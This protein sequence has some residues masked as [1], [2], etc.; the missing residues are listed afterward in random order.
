M[1]VRHYAF[2][3][4]VPDDEGER[5]MAPKRGLRQPRRVGLS[6]DQSWRTNVP[7]SR[8]YERWLHI[9]NRRVSGPTDDPS[10]PA[11]VE[12]GR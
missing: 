5:S 2:A 10:R 6:M 4:H 8:L 7:P 1:H 9:Q 11:T 12:P 3:V